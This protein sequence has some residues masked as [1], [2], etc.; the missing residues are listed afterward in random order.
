MPQKIASSLLAAALLLAGCDRGVGTPAAADGSQPASPASSLSTPDK[1]GP[2]PKG[3]SAMPDSMRT[4]DVK[5]RL[6]TLLRWDVSD[7]GAQKVVLTVLDPRK[8]V[9]KRFG[10]GGPV[11]SKQTGA[12]L[13][14]GLVFKVRDQSNN[15][16]LSAVTIAG[17][18]CR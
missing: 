4:C 13:R 12:W 6:T 5:R 16:E 1:L 17:T 8:G 3:I 2:P 15:A 18:A 9:E 14:P 10:K 7:S 11:G